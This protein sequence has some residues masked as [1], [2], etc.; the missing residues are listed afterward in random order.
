M[1]LCFASQPLF[2]ARER[3]NANAGNMKLNPTLTE[4]RTDWYQSASHHNAVPISQG[5][6]QACLRI[7]ISEKREFGSMGLC[8]VHGA[9]F[10][11]RV[12]KGA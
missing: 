8:V 11:F 3:C 7:R 2:V 4:S 5:Q 1:Q 10:S 9:L 12:H 6:H